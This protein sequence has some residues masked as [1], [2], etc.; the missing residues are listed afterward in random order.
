MKEKMLALSGIKR[1]ERILRYKFYQDAQKSLIGDIIV[2][3]IISLR[4]KLQNSR[5]TLSYSDKGKPYL[6]GCSHFFF[7]VSHAGDW[8]VA[9]FSDHEVG[10]DVERIKKIN[11]NV[12]EQ[13]FS[14]NENDH[15]S[16]LEGAEKLDYFFDLWTMKES[17]LKYTGKGLSEPLNSFTVS[18]SGDS[19]ILKHSRL[20]EEVFLKQ[21][22]LQ[23]GYKLAVCSGVDSFYGNIQFVDINE[24]IK[25]L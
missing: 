6:S 2:R 12:A 13:F 15:L 17:Y 23:E 9:A 19:F 8:V 18:R 11:Y 7:N 14:Q 25:S 22:Y 20:N 4:L 21:Y 5:I 10:I 24:C 16:E 3:S 1:R